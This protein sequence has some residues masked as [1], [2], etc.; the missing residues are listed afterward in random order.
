MVSTAR[1]LRLS[2]I[3]SVLHSFQ[4]KEASKIRVRRDFKKNRNNESLG[5]L[6]SFNKKIHALHCIATVLFPDPSEPPVARFIEQNGSAI[7]DT[8][9]R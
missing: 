3:Y 4:K 6:H 7:P 2:V 5:V 1:H 9:Q 8:A